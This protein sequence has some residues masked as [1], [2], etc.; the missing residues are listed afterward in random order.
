[1]S[2]RICCTSQVKKMGPSSEEMSK[3]SLVPVCQDEL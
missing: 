2:G 1:M 3:F